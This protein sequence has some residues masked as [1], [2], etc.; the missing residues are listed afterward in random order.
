[1]P[2]H[3]IISFLEGASANGEG[4]TLAQ[5]WEF[6]DEQ[7]ERNHSFIQ[8]VFPTD[9]KSGSNNLS[10]VLS[11][12]ELEMLQNNDAIARN[13]EK[14]ISWFLSFLSKYNHWITNY[15][16]NH[17]R[18]SRIIRSTALLHSVE[19]AKWFMDT[20]IEMAAHD[21]TALAVARLHWGVNLDEAT[22]IRNT[23]GRQDRALGAFIG[24]A[25]GDAMG[26]PVEFKPR[27]TFEPVTEFRAGGNFDLPKGAWTD[28][29]AMALC[30]SES[31]NVNS[32]IDPKDLLDRFCE[33]AEKGKNTSTGICVGIGQNTLRVLGNY[34][35]KGDL[36]APETR[37][38][39]DGNGSI[40]RLA[41]V[42][43]RHWKNPK[44]AQK[45]A[46][47]QSRITHYSEICAA[48]S[49]YLAGVLSKLIVGEKWND[50]LKVE[51]SMQWPKE[52]VIIS[53][54]GWKQKTA[55]EIK[56]TGYVID[57]LEAALWAVGTTDSFEAA[58]LK[59]VN[60]GDDADTVGAVAGQL[61]GA[62]YGMACIPEDWRKT[63]V[64]FEEISDN[65]N[66]LYSNS[67]K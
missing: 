28:D 39:S 42:A 67:L 47:K 14:S 6:D 44:Q 58:I 8:W 27:G 31:L 23:Y 17:L 51:N 7:I 54:K 41:P 62:R 50:A 53:S 26:A 19:L 21:K 34:H 63:L 43:V 11:V 56:S 13:I 66:C 36:I 49:D 33:W 3:A 52:L 37:Q 20:V 30:L 15:N 65:A 12:T 24:L 10:A 29:T 2:D 46:I 16:H 1:M 55:P 59:A 48:A 35:R 22:E 64:Q 57:T 38:K 61:A 32:D 18:V 45:I 60:L 9:L 40:M 25:I 5:I 4:L